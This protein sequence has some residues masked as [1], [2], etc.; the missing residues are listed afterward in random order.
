MFEGRRIM[1]RGLDAKDEGGEGEAIEFD[2]RPTVQRRE[3]RTV[4]K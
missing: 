3:E 1:A 4:E 2:R